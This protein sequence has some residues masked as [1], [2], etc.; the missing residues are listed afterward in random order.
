MITP[1]IIAKIEE[2]QRLCR[3]YDDA[4]QVFEASQIVCE[5]HYRT[6]EEFKQKWQ[7]AKEELS[8]MIDKSAFHG[9]QF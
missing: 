1:E 9:G 7:K 6:A 2:V 8:R 5:K 4:K 3:D